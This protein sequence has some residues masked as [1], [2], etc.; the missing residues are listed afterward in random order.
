LWY[1]LKAKIIITELKAS[2]TIPTPVTIFEILSFGQGVI[3]KRLVNPKHIPTIPIKKE[4]ISKIK[5][6]CS[7]LTNLALTKS[8]SFLFKVL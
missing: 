2:I 8:V 1:S 3:V 4:T 5:E 6:F 7:W